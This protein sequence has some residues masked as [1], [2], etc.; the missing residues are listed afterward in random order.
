MLHGTRGSWA[1]FGADVKEQQLMSGMLPDDPAFGHDPS[2]GI[3]Y[4]SAAGTQTEIPSPVGNQ[5]G[6]SSRV[7][8]S[9]SEIPFLA[10]V[11]FLF[12]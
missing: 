6:A 9:A 11:R 4:V 7:T 1:K 8:T 2:P 5:Q 10:K 3:I 12:Q